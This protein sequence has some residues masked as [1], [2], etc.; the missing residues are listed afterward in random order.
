MNVAGPVVRARCHAYKALAIFDHLKHQLSMSLDA[1]AI[2]WPI[3]AILFLSPTQR[4]KI[5]TNPSMRPVIKQ[6]FTWNVM[7]LMIS[8]VDDRS[9]DRTCRSGLL[10][11]NDNVCSISKFTQSCHNFWRVVPIGNYASPNWK[12]IAILCSVYWGASTDDKCL[13]SSTILQV[14]ARSIREI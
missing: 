1:V 2:A 12:R 6:V 10:A 14:T 11:T 7:I 8:S 9:A 5:H 4:P 13:M 3:Q